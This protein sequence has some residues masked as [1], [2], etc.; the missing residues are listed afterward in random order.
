MGLDDLIPEDDSSTN[1]TDNG[2]SSS[3]TSSDDTAEQR[4]SNLVEKDP[5]DTEDEVE[6]YEILEDTKECPECGVEGT[7]DEDTW[8]CETEDC[9]VEHFVSDEMVFYDTPSSFLGD[10]DWSEVRTEFKKPSDW[11][12]YMD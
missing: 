4:G 8:R 7:I 11:S 3:D 10:I 12:E 1:S 2:V 5:S 6:S 9:P